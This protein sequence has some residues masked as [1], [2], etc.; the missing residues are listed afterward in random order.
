ME[1]FPCLEREGRSSSSPS[2][3]N[4]NSTSKTDTLKVYVRVRPLNVREREVVRS[5]SLSWQIYGNQI[6]Q[7][8]AGKPLTY[9][10]YAFDR[11]FTPED[12]N[13]I[14]FEEAA[15]SVVDS[16]ID[17]YNGTIFAYGQT[18]S[19]KTHTMLGTPEDKGIIPLSIYQVF[20]RLER[21]EDREFLLRVSY[22]EIYNENIRDL[23]APHNE[24]LKVHEDFNGRVFVDAKEEVVDTP[25]TVLEIMKKGESNR[26]IGST[27]MNEHSSRSHTIFTV[28]I[29]SREKNRD[30]ESDGL[31]VRASTL[32]L[33]DL[34][35]SERV[36]QT[37]AE[38]SRLKEGMHINKSLLTLGTVI[39]KLCEGVN[40]H[41][42]YRDSKLTRILQPALGGNSKTTV[43]C[44]VTPAAMHIEETHSTLKF[45]SRAKKV[46]INAYCNEILDD[47]AMLSNYRKEIE[48]LRNQLTE[49]QQDRQ[50]GEK[51]LPYESGQEI[52][53]ENV[54]S[55][56]TLSEIDFSAP[57]KRMYDGYI[58]DE[59]LSKLQKLS[60]HH[61]VISTE[62]P[63]KRT[64]VSFVHASF[65]TFDYMESYLVS[66][67][68]TLKEEENEIQCLKSQLMQVTN[69]NELL[70]M[71]NAS[72]RK[73]YTELYSQHCF[74]VSQDVVTDLMNNVVQNEL[75]RCSELKCKQWEQHNRK[76]DEKLFELFQQKEE[77][78]NRIN[79]LE[80]DLSKK[81]SQLETYHTAM[82]PN[83]NQ[84][85]L[86]EN[87]SLKQKVTEL[88]SKCRSSKVLCSQA[89]SEKQQLE[90]ELKV[91]Q[92][93]LRKLEAENVKLKESSSKQKENSSQVNNLENKLEDLTKDREKTMEELQTLEKEKNEFMLENKTLLMKL[94]EARER[95]ENF[96]SDLEQSREESSKVAA[97]NELL[98]QENEQMRHQIV[99]LNDNLEEISAIKKSLSRN[100]EELEQRVHVLESSYN[101]LQSRREEEQREFEEERNSN[102]EQLTEAHLQL[103]Q[104]KVAIEQL[105]ASLSDEQKKSQSYYS[106]LEEVREKYVE[107]TEHWKELSEHKDSEFERISVLYSELLTSLESV[108][109][110][111]RQLERDVNDCSHTIL[112]IKERLE[113]VW[114]EK[115]QLSMELDLSKELRDNYK[116]ICKTSIPSLS[117]NPSTVISLLPVE[118]DDPNSLWKQEFEKT[119][120][121]LAKFYKE[122]KKLLETIHQRDQKIEQ[123]ENSYRNLVED[124]GVIGKLKH[125]LERRDADLKRVNEELRKVEELA[126]AA[127]K[128][129]GF[130]DGRQL[131]R[132]QA[133][134]HALQDQVTSLNRQIENLQ[135]ERQQLLEE[136]SRLRKEIK[137]RDL[138]R[139]ELEEKFCLWKQQLYQDDQN[140]RTKRKPPR[141]PLRVI[142]NETQ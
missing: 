23:L 9:C 32:T 127:C 50:G 12:N 130:E 78:E 97:Q 8:H 103:E 11:I 24:N 84:S 86:K 107:D 119:N 77:L 102:Y 133:D 139:I 38:G 70:E 26:T 52:I 37:G 128:G 6:T 35:G 66:L 22:I 74:R 54:D 10:S 17:G 79:A 29:E 36:S 67:E 57:R 30:I 138:H 27:N 108:D 19:G 90:R 96:R 18:S 2:D 3:N 135:N 34:A 72:Y 25:E 106:E 93:Q 80:A 126:V 55:E 61:C 132:L 136:S 68:N 82:L 92:K 88:E 81:T 140:G 120:Q 121:E 28:F 118:G 47:K 76:Q 21:I 56:P 131:V 113:L 48:M 69:N 123:L 117:I 71:E 65:D 46:K 4:H 99:S 91:L 112:L 60:T 43:I 62:S 16:V 100:V 73:R 137:K 104:S 116:P 124:N 7:C 42:P 53:R 125:K 64:V 31:S 41:I 59:H 101:E 141:P 83:G 40:S 129:S 111:R 95:V 45:A 58:N 109:S 94:E 105:Q 87:D 44:A 15:S 98:Q 49:L 85:I 142:P 39:N 110:E 115:Q 13:K 1:V 134:N 51:S 20:G 33:V 75:E 122:K 14:V 5:T 89:T 63:R 114:K